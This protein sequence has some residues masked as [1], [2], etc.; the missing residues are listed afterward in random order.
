M[1]TPRND[2]PWQRTAQGSNQ[3]ILLREPQRHKHD[4]GR[5]L[6]DL[7]PNAVELLLVALK[8]HGRARRTGDF[9]ARIAV[10]K[11]LRCPFRDAGIAAEQEYR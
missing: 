6:S 4:V 2:A 7:T 10:S 3:K 11:D 9:E 8:A 5:G 1:P